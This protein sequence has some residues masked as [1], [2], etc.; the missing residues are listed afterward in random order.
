MSTNSIIEETN[1]S[2]DMDQI[3][4]SAKN[5]QECVICSKN[6]VSNQNLMRHVQTVHKKIKPF[7]CN[8]C[9]KTFCE[10]CYLKRHIKT[11]H[12]KI[13]NKPFQCHICSKTFENHARLK[14]HVQTVHEKVKPFQCQI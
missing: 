9:L 6:F 5:N 1:R 10:N 8:L 12:E 4:G 13:Y 7:Q 3:K 2:E 11:V 14:I